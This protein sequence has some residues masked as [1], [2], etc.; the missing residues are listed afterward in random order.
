MSDQLTVEPRILDRKT[1]LE[2]VGHLCHLLPDWEGPLQ[3]VATMIEVAYTQE[4]HHILRNLTSNNH[5]TNV[6]QLAVKALLDYADDY[7]KS[8]LWRIRQFLRDNLEID[9]EHLGA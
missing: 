8:T 2:V 9:A 6:E 5:L 3:Y 7:A 4:M 1:A